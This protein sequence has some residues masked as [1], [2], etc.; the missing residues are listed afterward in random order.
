MHSENRQIVSS[1]V[2]RVFLK[3]GYDQRHP[4][5]P[6][7]VGRLLISLYSSPH[8]H[9]HNLDHLVDVVQRCEELISTE[10]CVAPEEIIIAALFHDA[11]YDP[12]N[13]SDC[14]SQSAELA[15]VVA[16]GG[17]I[18]YTAANRINALVI[19]TDT[20]EPKTIDQRI[21]C[22]ADL[23]ILG[24]EEEKYNNYSRKI[25][26][27][28]PNIRDDIFRDTRAHVLKEFLNKKHIFHTKTYREKYEDQARDNISR[29]VS[30]LEDSDKTVLGGKSCEYF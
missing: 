26:L 16:L 7:H 19:S 10:D 2:S 30:M 17:G 24:Q 27:E 9:Y 1:V 29:E 28:Y 3:F 25:K 11:I 5:Y 18:N 23:A 21:L 14:V 20:H 4:D 8:R 15:Y 6:I 12:D 13:G 22:D